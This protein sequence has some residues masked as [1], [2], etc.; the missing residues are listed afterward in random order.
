VFVAVVLNRSEGFGS[1][2]KYN[3]HFLAVPNISSGQH[4]ELHPLNLA[5]GGFGWLLFFLKEKSSLEKF[6][7]GISTCN[8]KDFQIRIDVATHNQSVKRGKDNF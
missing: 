5:A 3:R 6:S 8:K 1:F 7:T 2:A 4:S